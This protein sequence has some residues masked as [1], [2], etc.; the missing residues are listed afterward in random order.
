MSVGNCVSSTVLA[1]EGSVEH[2]ELPNGRERANLGVVSRAG[3]E[4]QR[5]NQTIQSQ[6]LGKDQN[7]TVHIQACP[8]ASAGVRQSGRGVLGLLKA[9]E[10]HSHHS[11]KDTGL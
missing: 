10:Q 9:Q 11:N 2:R 5:N 4:D 1:R 3:V 7:E 6:H 8:G